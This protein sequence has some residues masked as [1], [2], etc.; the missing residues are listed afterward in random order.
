MFNSGAHRDKGS[1]LNGRSLNDA[2]WTDE[3][4][5]AD[6]DIFGDVSTVLDDSVVAD[7]NLFVTNE[8]GSVPN[9]SL[10]TS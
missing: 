9:G 4:V 10:L 2:V 3:Y 1:V 8:C 5:I 7:L 6:G